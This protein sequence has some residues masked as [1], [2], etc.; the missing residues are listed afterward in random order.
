MSEPVVDNVTNK[1]EKMEVK[2][3]TSAPPKEKKEKKSNK[4]QLKTPKG[5]QDYNPRQ[6]TIREQVFDGIKQ[7]FK[8]HG[9]VTIETPVFELKVIYIHIHTYIYIYI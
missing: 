1:V 7:V 8:R 9:A 3:K 4:V 2:E 6:M 5:T